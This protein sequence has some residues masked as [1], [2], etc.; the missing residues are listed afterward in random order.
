CRRGNPRLCDAEY[1]CDV[2]DTETKLRWEYA[3]D[4]IHAYAMQ[5]ILKRAGE[6]VQQRLSAFGDKILSASQIPWYLQSNGLYIRADMNGWSWR[7]LNNTLAGLEYCLFRRGIFREVYV[8]AVID[9]TALDAQGERHLSLLRF[10]DPRQNGPRINAG[11]QSCFNPETGTRFLYVAGRNV[12]PYN[13][14]ELLD[15]AQDYAETKIHN[16]GDRRLSPNDP[17]WLIRSH[18]LILTAALD[19][20]SWQVL[21]HTIAA[22]RLC[23][24]ERSPM[25]REV[26]VYNIRDPVA[27]SGQRLLTLKKEF[28]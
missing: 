21:N 8:N 10:P 24:S 25:K 9:P 1:G 28:R 14:Q 6:L 3:D 5:E 20:W 11:T 22:L 27:M 15:A 17:A 23:E 18:G 12:L 4:T 16:G 13:M 26:D 19:G 7:M 2:P